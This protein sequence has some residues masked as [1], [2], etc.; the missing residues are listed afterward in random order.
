MSDA[1]AHEVFDAG[2]VAIRHAGE[3]DIEVLRELF[4]RSRSEG[5]LREN[6]TGA[7]LEH[8]LEGY[9][10]CDGSGFWVADHGGTVVGMIGVQRLTDSSAEVRRLRVRLE[11][12]RRGIGRL[13]MEHAL[14]FCRQKQY[15][16]V[17]LD[18]ALEHTG[19]VSMFE[20]FG[21][22]HG[23]T[24]ELDGRTLLDFYLDL[25]SDTHG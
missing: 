14:D 20:G 3:A 25:Y 8:L 4:D 2:A 15:L 7:D 18:V 5:N 10:D 6:D 12:R 23:H 17:V 21:F 22:T 19:A 24:R 13:L 9:L 11:F 16:K 1:A